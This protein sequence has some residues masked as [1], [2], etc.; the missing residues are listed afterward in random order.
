MTLRLES[1]SNDPAHAC[2]EQTLPLIFITETLLRRFLQMVCVSFTRTL[3]SNDRHALNARLS[4][5]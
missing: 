5:E 4:V 2:R 3:V 1:L